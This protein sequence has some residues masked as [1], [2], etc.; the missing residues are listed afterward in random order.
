MR[1]MTTQRKGCASRRVPDAVMEQGY[2]KYQRSNITLP[3][4][5]AKRLL[6]YCEDEHRAKSWCIQ[7]ALDEWLAKKNY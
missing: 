3:P 5:L 7:K 6:K 4:E 2:E 1:I